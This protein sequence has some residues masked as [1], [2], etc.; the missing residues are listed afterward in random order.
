MRRFSLACYTRL[1]EARG[2]GGMS[3][4]PPS[5]LH[6]T[7]QTSITVTCPCAC[8]HQEYRIGSTDKTMVRVR[9]TGKNCVIPLLHTGRV[10]LLVAVLCDSLLCGW[11]VWLDY[12][13]G[14]LL[15]LLLLRVNGCQVTHCIIAWKS[16]QFTYRTDQCQ[17]QSVI[18]SSFHL[19][20]LIITHA[21]M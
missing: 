12:N 6:R 10:W 19:Q 4:A 16:V 20:P 13:E 11:A 8:I 7:Q 15:L 21:R 14:N 9:V 1:T 5:S 2:S 18:N 3:L 17:M